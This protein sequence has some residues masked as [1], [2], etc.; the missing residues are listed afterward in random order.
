VFAQTVGNKKIEEEEREVKAE[1]INMKK[2]STDG[3]KREGHYG[4]FIFFVYCKV[5][6]CQTVHK[7]TFSSTGRAAYG[8]EA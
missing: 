5:L 1:W 2:N 7:N 4:I 6:G 3:K 8:A